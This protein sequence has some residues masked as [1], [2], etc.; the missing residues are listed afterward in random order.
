M[1]RSQIRAT[2]PAGSLFPACL[3]NAPLVA[4]RPPWTSSPSSTPP[5]DYPWEFRPLPPHWLGYRPKTPVDY[6][7][8]GLSLRADLSKFIGS[9]LSETLSIPVTDAK[10]PVLTL[11][12]VTQQF[13]VS[14]KTIR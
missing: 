4:R 8:A 2:V 14:S 10:E 1:A 11:D 6:H 7:V 9:L 5:K 3:K 12:Q 13:N